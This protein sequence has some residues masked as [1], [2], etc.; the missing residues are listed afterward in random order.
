MVLPSSSSQ[1][2]DN[3]NLPGQFMPIGEHIAQYLESS[4]AFVE[5]AGEEGEGGDGVLST[6]LLFCMG[7][8][9]VNTLHVASI[10]SWV[11]LLPVVDFQFN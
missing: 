6:N 7:A 1:S 10:A 2:E 5:A 9:F 11:R 3:A 8:R 4:V